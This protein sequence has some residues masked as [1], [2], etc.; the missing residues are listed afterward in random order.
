[1]TSTLEKGLQ[2]SA[3]RGATQKNGGS[4]QACDVCHVMRVCVC[5][6]PFVSECSF[7]GVEQG[8]QRETNHP[9]GGGPNPY[10]DTWCKGHW[11]HTATASRLGSN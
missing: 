3:A 1:M 8:T 5:V 7:F 2:L 9:F 4:L 11:S 10:F 6:C